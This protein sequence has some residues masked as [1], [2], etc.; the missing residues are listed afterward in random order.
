VLK[1]ISTGEL[2]NALA[3]LLRHDVPGLTAGAISWLEW[4]A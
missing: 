4:A 3:A 2:S 1:G